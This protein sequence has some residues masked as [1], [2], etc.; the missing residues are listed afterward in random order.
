L[1]QP[2]N[3]EEI[4]AKILLLLKDP[5]MARRMGM[6]AR[7]IVEDKFDSNKRIDKIIQLYSSLCS[8]SDV[9]SGAS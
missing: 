1:V 2:R 6:N 4:A 9:G 7:K 8:R 5:Q 3:H